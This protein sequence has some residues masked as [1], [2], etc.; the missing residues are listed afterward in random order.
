MPWI[1][2]M[3]IELILPV[4]WTQLFWCLNAKYPLALDLA[5]LS[6]TAAARGDPERAAQ[7]LGASYGLLKAMGLGQ[8]PADQVELDRYE[9]AVR[10]QICEA[11]FKAA[12]ERGQNMSLE[13]AIAYA[14]EEEIC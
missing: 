7:L 8:Q 2:I 11:A 6:G 9:A 12:W 13:Q 5:G 4:D 3:K 10:E 1:Y 14:L